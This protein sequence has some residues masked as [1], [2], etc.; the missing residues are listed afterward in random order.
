MKRTA[1]LL[2]L[3]FAALSA[4][5][6][7]PA[8]FVVENVPAFPGTLVDN[9]RPY[10]EFRTAGLSDWNP[11][12]REILIRTRFGDVAQLHSVKMPG[13]AECEPTLVGQRQVARIFFHAPQRQGH[14]IEFLQEYAVK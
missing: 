4:F 7:V 3:L 14:M 13:G 5:A 1:L 2:S 10:L 8:N 12:R 6:H 11:A 9:V